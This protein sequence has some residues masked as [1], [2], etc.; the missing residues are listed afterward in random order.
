MNLSRVHRST[1]WNGVFSEWFH[2]PCPTLQQL[3]AHAQKHLSCLHFPPL[4]QCACTCDAL[5]RQRDPVSL[6]R[7]LGG[8]CAWDRFLFVS[9]PSLGKHE[10]GIAQLLSHGRRSFKPNQ[11]RYGCLM[12]CVQLSGHGYQWALAMRPRKRVHLQ[13]CQ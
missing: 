3:V 8:I 10:V 2:L 6:K 11:T 5:D 12:G 13:R 7:L 4:L 1:P 9:P